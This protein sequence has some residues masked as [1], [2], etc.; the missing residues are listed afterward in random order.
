MEKETLRKR[1]DK[2]ESAQKE[3]PTSRGSKGLL[4]MNFHIVQACFTR[5]GL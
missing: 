5:I 2:F 3:G 1:P 4:A